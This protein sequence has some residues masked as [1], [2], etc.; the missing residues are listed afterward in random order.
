MK[1]FKCYDFGYY[2][3]ECVNKK[4]MILFERGEL[5]FEDEKDEVIEEEVVDYL[6]CGEFS[7]IFFGRFW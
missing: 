6:V 2:I 5:I 7:Y 1:C 4:V 3:S